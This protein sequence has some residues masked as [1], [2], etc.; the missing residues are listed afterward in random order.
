MQIKVF[1]T[2]STYK[3]LI[4]LNITVVSVPKMYKEFF[5]INVAFLVSKIITKLNKQHLE[6]IDKLTE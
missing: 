3:L 4:M 6:Y 2:I 5:C 1:Y